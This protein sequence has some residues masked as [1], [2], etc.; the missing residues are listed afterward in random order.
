MAFPRGLNSFRRAH[1]ALLLAAFPA[2][3]LGACGTETRYQV[4]CIFFEGVPPPGEQA[5]PKLP[6]AAK[7]LKP[8]PVLLES[9]GSLHPPVRDRLC[10]ECHDMPDRQ[11]SPVSAGG[12]YSFN[13]VFSTNVAV[14]REEPRRLCF[15]CHGKLLEVKHL[16]GPVANGLCLRCH[17]PHASAY[18]KLL[19][20]KSSNDLCGSCHG[21][22]NFTARS[23]HAAGTPGECT[24][25][26]GPHGGDLEYFL[27]SE[28]VNA[29]ARGAF[30]M[31]A[32]AVA[33][34]AII[35]QALYS[36]RPFP[37]VKGN[38][39]QGIAQ[40][41]EEGRLQILGWLRDEELWEHASEAER[42]IFD[43]PVGSSSPKKEIRLDLQKESLMVMIYAL[44]IAPDLPPFGREA[45]LDLLKKIPAANQSTALFIQNAQLRSWE[46]IERGKTITEFWEL[47]ARA[48]D[49]LDSGNFPEGKMFEELAMVTTTAMIDAG[50]QPKPIADGPSLFREII[51]L[52]AHQAF[53]EGWMDAPV[54]DDF[55]VNGRP[56]RE[57][58]KT[59]R[60][61]VQAIARERLRAFN[62]LTSP[63]KD[64]DELES[65]Q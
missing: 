62:W 65:D 56:Y 6:A 44:G 18:K 43:A 7:G 61:K 14:M 17:Q 38:D 40:K 1:G 34:R 13:A 26:H 55:P 12:V 25:C 16:H 54:E 36:A 45:S 57:L 8:Y 64:W 24:D 47:R 2:L 29:L 15:K 20:V 52:S 9:K 30:R 51:R 59:V 35:L 4:L 39:P 11:A 19:R 50:L 3:I 63:E 53:K 21:I 5:R 33:R 37:R 31:D 41:H 58:E 27:R 49:L 32:Q 48:Q 10:H 46:D 60:S 22:Q 28:T 42:N 23:G